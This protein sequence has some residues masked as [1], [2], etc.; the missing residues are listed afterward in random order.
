[1][2]AEIQGGL[3]ALKVALDL[4]KAGKGAVDA[5]AMANALFEIQ[6]R[7]MDTQGAALQAMEEKA[8]LSKKV[9]ELENAL[10]ERDEWKI[11]AANYELSEVAQG[12]IAFVERGHEGKLVNAVKL[13]A[14]CFSQKHKSFLQMQHMH[15]NRER[16]LSCARCKDKLV[17]RSFTDQS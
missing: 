3:T 7:L 17:F 14:N 6:Q 5:A 1:M 2:Y 4:A 12:I 16:S 10:R 15:T 11:E 8:A 9:E 13:C